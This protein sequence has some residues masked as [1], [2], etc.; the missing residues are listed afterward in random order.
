MAIVACGE[1]PPSQPL[2]IGA[3]APS[4]ELT[5]VGGGRVSLADLA[6][7]PRVLVF[8][9]T[10]CQPC[11]A[12]IPALESIEAEHPGRIVSIALD[13]GG[14]ADVARFLE[15]RPIPYRVLIGDAD[16]FARYDGLAIP[17]TVVLDRDLKVVAVH[18]GIVDR[19][20]LESSLADL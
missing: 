3:P 17:H 4:F 10:W 19:D 7:E 14:A 1:A 2:A 6:G 13:E 12:E 16:L 9:A 11:L 15:N 5:R 8:W 18:R 20:V